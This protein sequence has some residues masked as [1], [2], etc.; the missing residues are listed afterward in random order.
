MT[1]STLPCKLYLPPNISKQCNFISSRLMVFPFI[2]KKF[3]LSALDFRIFFLTIN[4]PSPPY[5]DTGFTT[6]F[7]SNLFHSKFSTSSLFLNLAINF[8]TPTPAF[9]SFLFVLYLLSAIPLPSAVFF[10]K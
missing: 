1:L 6:K 9:S 2:I 7:P 5:P 10:R 4:I 3:M 8:G